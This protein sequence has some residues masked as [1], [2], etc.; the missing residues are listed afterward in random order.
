M[1]HRLKEEW[2]SIPFEVLNDGEVTA[3]A[4]SMSLNDNSVLGIAMGTSTAAGYCDAR[5]H[6]T[7]RI[8]E[9]ASA[10]VDYRADAPADEWSGDL[11]CG[12]QYFSQQGVA[13]LVPV[14]GIDLPED[15]PA[16]ETLVEVQRLMAEG[17]PRAHAIYETIGTCFGYAIAHYAEFYD[18]RHLLFLGRVSSGEGG[19][20]I[21]DKAEEALRADF[22]E[23][24]EQIAISM[25]DE[26]L[27]RHGQAIAAA[28]LPELQG[29]IT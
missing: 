18:I 8:N 20:V 2:G 16:A 10:P 4:G 12:V 22:P 26:K 25:P 7:A 19:Q 29:D 28:S 15:M 23:L 17:D 5:G 11:G 3:L 24:A 27:K 13:R 21:V 6:L 1:F 9:L 14:A